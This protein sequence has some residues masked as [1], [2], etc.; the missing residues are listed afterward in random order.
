MKNKFI[1]LKITH[2]TRVILL[3]FKDLNTSASNGR[4]CI[5]NNKLKSTSCRSKR[6]EDEEVWHNIVVGYCYATL[7][8]TNG[9]DYEIVDQRSDRGRD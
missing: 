3:S 8:A 4:L 7:K 2:E 6:E 9:T 5:Y 1:N